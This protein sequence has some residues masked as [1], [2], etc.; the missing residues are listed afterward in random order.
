MSLIIM[1]IITVFA[2]ITFFASLVFT[3]EKNY[4]FI[5][6]FG[7]YHKTVGSGLAFKIPYFASVDKRVY[8]GLTSNAVN[9]NLKTKDEVT[10]KLKVNV[11][12]Q[13]SSTMENAYKAV[14]DINNYLTEMESNAVDVAIPIANNIDIVDVYAKKELILEAIEERLKVF[15]ADYGITIIKVLSDEPKLPEELERQANNIMIAKRE[16]EAA[17]D[18][19]DSI[20]II[21]VGEAKADGESVKIRMQKQGEAREE[22]AKRTASAISELVNV[23]CSSDAALGFLNQI[24]EQDAIVTSSRNGATMIFHTSDKGSQ[25]SSDAILAQLISDKKDAVK[26]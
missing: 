18:K 24:G 4:S 25:N 2:I 5:T 21:R 17:Q 14:Y 7:K 10:F 26:A 16:K 3:P 23:N 15:F 12:Y 9:L 11:Q 1:S 6:I 22:Y 19:A 13:I 8:Y 20:R